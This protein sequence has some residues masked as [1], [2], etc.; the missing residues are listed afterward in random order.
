MRFT[1]TPIAGAY[2][3]EPEPHADERG[4]FA[5]TFCQTE[6]SAHG[7]IDR[8]AQCSTS[9][10]KLRGTLRGMHYQRPPYAETKLVRCTRGE[11]FDVLIDLRRDSPSYGQWFGT[12][13]DDENRSQLYIPDGC[14]HGFQTLSENAEVLYMIDH[15]YV[16]RAADGVRWDDSFFNIAWPLPITAIAERDKTYSNWEGRT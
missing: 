13:L 7:L 10:S 3:I 11:I 12:R 14:A 16:P 9:M 6:F 2:L 8:Y 1:Q 4:L 15:E 5:R